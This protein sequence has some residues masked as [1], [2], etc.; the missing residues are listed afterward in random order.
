MAKIRMQARS[1]DT[2]DAIALQTPQPQPHQYHHESSK[3]VGALQILRRVQKAEGFVGWYQARV[4]LFEAEIILSFA[5]Q[6]MSAQ[7]VKAVLQ[8]ALLFLTKEQFERWA[9]AIIVLI[10][11]LRRKA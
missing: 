11:R 8:Q 1:A 6:G 7:I 5:F 2:D 4:L 9:L 3:H 10:Y